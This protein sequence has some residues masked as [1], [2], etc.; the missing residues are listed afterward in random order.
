MK[1]SGFTQSF[2]NKPDQTIVVSSCSGMIQA[3]ALLTPVSNTMGAQKTGENFSI[4]CPSSAVRRVIV[5]CVP[6]PACD[7]HMLAPHTLAYIIQKKNS[8]SQQARRDVLPDVFLN[9]IDEMSEQNRP[10]HICH[11]SR[12]GGVSPSIWAGKPLEQATKYCEN[13]RQDGTFCPGMHI[14]VITMQSPLKPMDFYMFLSSNTGLQNKSKVPSEKTKDK[15]KQ[16][17]G[18]DQG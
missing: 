4:W 13:V 10:L 17:Q 6:S 8:I 7:F 5:R 3:K 14:I 16:V 2:S 1:H 18:R 11:Y 9:R 15:R 12:K